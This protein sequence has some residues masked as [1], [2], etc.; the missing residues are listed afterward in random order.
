MGIFGE[1]RR[2]PVKYE[3]LPKNLINAFIAGEDARFFVHP[4]IDYQGLTRAAFQ[5]IR[6]GEKTQ[7]GSTITQQ[8]ARNFYLSSEKTYLRKIREIFLAIKI[9]N[10]FTKEEIL[11]LYLN[12]IFLGHR[13]YGVGAAAEVYY[14][15]SLHELSVAQA[16]MLAALPKAPSRI[17][18][19]SGPERAL[20]RRNYVLS[21]M[22]QLDYLSKAEYQQAKSEKDRAIYHGPSVELRAPYLAE[23]AR[24]A[25]I[26]KLGKNAYTG[27]YSLFMTV[28]SK[29]QLAANLAI[30]AGLDNYDR[31]HGYRG[32]EASIEL[33]AN[34]G[35]E[36]WREIL[37][38]YQEIAGL[39]PALVTEI[40]NDLALV[41]LADGQTIGLDINSVSWARAY[42]D[43][44]RRE[45]RPKQ[46]GD[47]LQPG[48]VIRISRVAETPEVTAP[49][50]SEANEAPAQPDVP[51]SG[52]Q[53]R[54]A[55]LP[56][57]EGAL[58]S[59]SP[60]SGEILA[61]VGGY[62][63]QRSHFNRVT[64][65]LRQPGSGFKPFVYS[66]ALSTGITPATLINDA[67]VV[68]NDPLLE[69]T[70][71][72]QNY[73]EKFFGPTRLREAMIHSRNLVSIRLLREI[74]IGAARNYIARFG[75]DK[76]KLPQDLSMA[77]GSGSLTPLSIARGYAVFANGG[78]LVDVRFMDRIENASGQIVYSP[79]RTRVCPDCIADEP[80]RETPQEESSVTEFK[81]LEISRIND[82]AV[83]PA[84]VRTSENIRIGKEVIAPQVIP[85]SNAWQIRSLMRDVIRFGTGRK[86]LELKRNDLSGKT[87]T[88]NDQ[89]DAWFSGY[90]SDIV[91]T[92]WVGFDDSGKLGRRETGG[93]AALP[94]WNDFMKTALA[95]S[96]D[97]YPQMADGLV[98]IRID[99]Q[100]GLASK[101]SSKDIIDEYFEFN[102][103]PDNETSLGVDSDNTDTTEEDDFEVF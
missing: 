61:L 36:Q 34:D 76:N 14:G 42:I 26:Q 28:D 93:Q 54:L 73:S 78:Y 62:D 89:R 60:L 41:Y 22:H 30:K 2:I 11:T 3:E 18:P 44:D 83:T 97:N 31:R 23:M 94:I 39:I 85:A 57:V 86:A 53:W 55:Q 70:W 27:G 43:H 49:E 51:G 15:K 16:A 67:P 25:A 103:L 71:K 38:N 19:I 48:D 66:A 50:P 69:K 91:T 10:A 64:Q 74:G 80:V 6:T 87:G 12:K 101:R 99:K 52:P 68:F 82:E 77:L 96:Q 46:V 20:I 72:P 90:N 100:T 65:S 7:G 84:S 56:A 37:Q 92:V 8:L 1:R 79:E 35:P 63:F 59:L 17:N 102:N 24:N 29:L 47:V 13:A 75:I 21:R 32:A 95:N 98:K 40:S 5:L 81:P 58:V 45:A 4:G 88:T 9:E 33:A